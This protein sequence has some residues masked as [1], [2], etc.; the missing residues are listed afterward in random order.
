MSLY[1][2]PVVIP[3]YSIFTGVAITLTGLRFWARTS[4]TKSR[5][6]TDDWLI[7][8][9]VLIGAAC[10]GIQLWNSLEGTGGEA[11]SPE[12]AEEKA[13]ISKK[14]D[15]TMVLIEKLAFG[16][17]KLSL[18]F[19][20]KRIFGPWASF[21][22]INTVFIWIVSLWTFSFIVADVTLCGVH[23]G[24]E[25][26]LDQSDAREHCGNKG[27]LLL[28]F[29]ITSLIT[30]L[31]VLSLPFFF[32]NRLQMPPQKKWAAGMVFLLGFM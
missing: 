11:V 28:M 16:A 24:D 8:V 27:L 12:D 3:I 19:F 21:K 9:G 15:F 7:A 17:I 26:K 2:P 22:R 18:L 20:Y 14:V 10:C 6:G 32:I 13:I 1:P 23:L 30:D 25:F 5:L 4:Y 31:L 29:A